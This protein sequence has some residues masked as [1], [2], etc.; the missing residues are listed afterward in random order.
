MYTK[1]D[2]ESN[3]G[4]DVHIAVKGREKKSKEI[5]K[6]EMSIAHLS[7]RFGHSEGETLYA[8]LQSRIQNKCFQRQGAK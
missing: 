1:D 7:G 5:I 3:A 2:P 8:M 6:V 4:P